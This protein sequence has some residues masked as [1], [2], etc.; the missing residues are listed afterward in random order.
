[1]INQY[2]ITQGAI[3]ASFRVRFVAANLCI[4]VCDYLSYLCVCFVRSSNWHFAK[5]FIRSFICTS[6]NNDD[7]LYNPTCMLVA[8]TAHGL[9]NWNGLQSLL[10]ML[11]RSTICAIV[12]S[13]TVPYSLV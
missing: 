11:L 13:S 4:S 3:S 12:R 10:S 6:E 7:M 8:Y 1:M 9:C 5:S 2:G